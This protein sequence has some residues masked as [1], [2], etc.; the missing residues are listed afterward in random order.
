MTRTSSRR[1]HAVFLLFVLTRY[2]RTLSGHVVLDLHVAC[3]CDRGFSRMSRLSF[4]PLH[5]RL[6]STPLFIMSAARL[7]MYFPTPCVPSE[8]RWCMYV[9]NKHLSIHCSILALTE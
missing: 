7:T 4:T 9:C 6:R 5:P 2:V 3:V 1:E 8:R